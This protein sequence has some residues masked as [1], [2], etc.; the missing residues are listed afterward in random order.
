MLKGPEHAWRGRARSKLRRPSM[1]LRLNRNNIWAY[2]G[3][4]WSGLSSRVAKCLSGSGSATRVG[5]A[6]YAQGTLGGPHGQT[7]T[8]QVPGIDVPVM[9]RPEGDHVLRKLGP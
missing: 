3:L 4:I 9:E 5:N 1:L 6:G 2:S 7:Q 8:L